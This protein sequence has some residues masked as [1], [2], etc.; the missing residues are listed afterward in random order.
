MQ[1]YAE[2]RPVRQ[3]AAHELVLDQMR[4]AIESG[5]FR[6]GDRLPPERD[7]AEQLD[8]SR[9]TVREAL[10][11]LER[12]G[13]LAVK[14]GR[15]G[16][17]VVQ[18]PEHDPDVTRLRLQQNREEIRDAFEYRAIVESAAARFA[19]ARRTETDLITLRA[20]FD[21][22]STGLEKYLASQEAHHVAGFL[23]ID[24]AFH[25][26]IANAARNAHLAVAV[27]ESRQ[28]M[29]D[30]VGSLFGRLEQNANDFHGDIL[31]AITDK[32]RDR[33]GELMSQ[34]VLDTM[35]TLEAWLRR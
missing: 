35:H 9:T 23:A 17:F 16:G 4:R 11:V 6:P 27:R 2:L 3:I 33:A 7:M 22:M 25:A 1:Q 20:M 28:T 21:S 19:A 10:G 24:A 12:E 14:R 13:S 18:A 30:P 15:G 5:Q 29:W 32:D 31:E 26:G 34:H 8:V